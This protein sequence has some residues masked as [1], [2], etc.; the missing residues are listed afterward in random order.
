MRNISEADYG[1]L[2]EENENL[3]QQVDLLK[4]QFEVTKGH[5][6]KMSDVQK[7]AK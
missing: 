5:A 6:P 1:I 4:Q 2:L 7:K 3:K